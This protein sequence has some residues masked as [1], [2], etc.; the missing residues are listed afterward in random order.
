MQ[1]RPAAREFVLVR[2]TRM[3]GVDLD[4]FDFDFDL[5]WMAF[6][7]DADGRVL[8]RYGGRDADGPDGRSSLA[9]LRYALERALALHK[10]GKAPPPAR[11]ARPRTVEDL[12]AARRLSAWGCVHCHQ[13]YDLRR[14]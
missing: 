4:L 14:E 12:P 10:S 7:L 13:V 2:L 11:A 1:I 5:T 6:F 3:R 8:G 9:G